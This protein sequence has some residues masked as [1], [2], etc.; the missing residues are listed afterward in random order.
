MHKFVFFKNCAIAS[1][2]SVVSYLATQAPC[3]PVLP[4]SDTQPVFLP[5]HH[6]HLKGFTPAITRKITSQLHLGSDGAAEHYKVKISVPSNGSEIEGGTL[7]RFD[8]IC[9]AVE[10]GTVLLRRSQELKLI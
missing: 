10:L 8:I 4:S 2:T 5:F 1:S 7:K 9:G 6:P 3:H